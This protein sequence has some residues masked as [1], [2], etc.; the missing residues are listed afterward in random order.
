MATCPLMNH[1]IYEKVW[2]QLDIVWEKKSKMQSTGLISHSCSSMAAVGQLI[3][4]KTED[5]AFLYLL[6]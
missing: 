3:E 6:Y 4:N 2:L 1:D 5:L